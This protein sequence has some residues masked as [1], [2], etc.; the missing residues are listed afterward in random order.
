MKNR[1]EEMSLIG[2]GNVY[3]E[4]TNQPIQEGNME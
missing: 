1:K 3:N 2:E 4:K